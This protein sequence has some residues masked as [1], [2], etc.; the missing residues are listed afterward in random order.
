MSYVSVFIKEE[1]KTKAVLTRKKDRQAQLCH[2]NTPLHI[3]VCNKAVI[4]L[5]KGITKKKLI[6]LIFF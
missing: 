6:T 5:N 1:I 3:S 4:R 2:S